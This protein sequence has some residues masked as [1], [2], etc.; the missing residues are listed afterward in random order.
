MVSKHIDGTSDRTSSRESI[1]D[2]A[3]QAFMEHGF[4]GSRVD[5][6]ASTA[7]ANKA[8][9]YYHFGS[10][11]GLYRAVLLRLFKNV[12]EEIERL[13]RSDLEPDE[14]LRALYTRVVLH[15]T[16]EL[17]LPHIMLREIL[18]GGK[19]MDG[20]ASRTL[21][22]ILGFV[23]EILEE[24]TRKGMFRKVDPLLLHFTILGPLLV[25][26]AGAAFRERLLPR[27]LPGLNPPT[28]DDMLAHLLQVLDRSLLPD[29]LAPS[30]RNVP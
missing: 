7:G 23:S 11:Q 6:I 20:E 10:K 4:S 13:R 9:I 12:I 26:F 21:G 25:Y 3:T 30:Q 14:K 29:H 8:M 16:E 19:A 28:H 2:S 18:A 27:A 22:T 1:L 24:G 17:A 5:Q 15:F